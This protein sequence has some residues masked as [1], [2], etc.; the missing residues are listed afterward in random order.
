VLSK[1][2]TRLAYLEFLK[3]PSAN[4]LYHHYRYYRVVYVEHTNPY[5]V[6][7]AIIV[8]LSLFQ[9]AARYGMYESAVRSATETTHFKS[10][11]NHKYSEALKSNPDIVI[12]HQHNRANLKSRRR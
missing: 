10:L 7:V 11:L 5:V 1:E 4:E 12:G 9:F 2:E 8:S 3:N 6:V